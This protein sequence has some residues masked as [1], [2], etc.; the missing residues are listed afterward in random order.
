MSI[1]PI[2]INYLSSLLPI[3]KDNDKVRNLAGRVL[4]GDAL[5]QAVDFLSDKEVAAT[6]RNF[7]K[8]CEKS[9]FV[10]PNNMKQEDLINYLEQNPNLKKLDLSKYKNFSL[11]TD[12]TLN[13][14]NK[15]IL[16]AIWGLKKLE[17]F[18]F[19]ENFEIKDIY[20]K[21][22]DLSANNKL[23]HVL[24]R[25]DSLTHVKLT[26]MYCSLK[27]FKGF[28]LFKNNLIS[29]ELP[30][31]CIPSNNREDDIKAKHDIIEA[32]TEIIENNKDLKY[33]DLFTNYKNIITKMIPILPKYRNLLS[34][35]KKISKEDYDL[36]YGLLLA[37][38]FQKYIFGGRKP[39]SILDSI[40]CSYHCMLTVQYKMMMT[41]MSSLA[42]ISPDI[43]KTLSPLVSELGLTILDQ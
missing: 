7:A 18:I 14:Q 25:L 30:N 17:E 5:R 16:M 42:K 33:L 28:A 6:S 36:Y 20:L 34:L 27:D 11:F 15:K 4:H 1:K 19:P 2:G 22:T 23:L 40:S 26:G 3:L 24:G 8:I 35:Q 29:I 13:P 21:K 41:T 39:D 38:V 37:I 9:S 12:Q 32:L 43:Q 10:V 31:I